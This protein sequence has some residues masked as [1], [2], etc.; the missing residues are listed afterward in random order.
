MT[1]TPTLEEEPEAESCFAAP[2]LGV[3]GVEEEEAA[4][5]GAE[6][7]RDTVLLRAAAA[8]VNQTKEA[9]ALAKPQQQ[10]EVGVRAR[11]VPRRAD[12]APTPLG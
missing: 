2:A 8:V 1:T 4:E 10:K 11:N 9:N 12:A 3:V 6:A 5:P 7:G